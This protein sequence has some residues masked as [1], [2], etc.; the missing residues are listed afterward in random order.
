MRN[1][2]NAQEKQDY[3]MFCALLG[4]TQDVFEKWHKHGNMTKDEIKRWRTART[5][6]E[7][8]SDSIMN[9]I[10]KSLSKNLM[11]LAK[12]TEIFCLPRERA[13]I[14]LRA[15]RDKHQNE[16]CEVKL[17]TLE[18]LAEKALGHCDP[19]KEK[20]HNKCMLKKLFL[21]LNIAPID[22]DT[23]GCGYAQSVPCE[24]MPG[25]S[26]KRREQVG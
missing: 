26:I 20:D 22:T 3:I 1:Y 24:E 12:D 18:D 17:S 4:Y 15:E 5:N 21:E 14:K 25:W 16:L 6:L 2:M 10:D 7:K 11:K 8:M 13:L 19:C 23:K 9:R